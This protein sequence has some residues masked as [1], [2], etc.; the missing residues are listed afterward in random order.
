MPN[1]SINPKSQIRNAFYSN[2]GWGPI[3][4]SLPPRSLRQPQ[5]VRRGQAV[6]EG[7][8]VAEG[9]YDFLVARDFE[10]LRILGP[11]VAIPDDEVAIGKRVQR[12]H[13]CQRDS[14]KFLL[15][16]APD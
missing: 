12:R 16:D 2:S 7:L 1:I 11:G 3:F 8:E 10:Q 5:H 13:P 6:A 15:V 4:P 9:P 14:R